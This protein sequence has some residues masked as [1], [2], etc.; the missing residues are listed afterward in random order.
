MG[1]RGKRTDLRVRNM[2]KNYDNLDGNTRRELY[3]YVTNHDTYSFTNIVYW[4]NNISDHVMD[5]INFAFTR[6][7]NNAIH[8]RYFLL[9]QC[10]EQYSITIK[11]HI[12][13]EFAGRG[14]I[15]KDVVDLCKKISGSIRGGLTQYT[16]SQKFVH[17]YTSY[18]DQSQLQRELDF[19][20]KYAS[21]YTVDDFYDGLPL[22]YQ[23]GVIL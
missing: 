21:G 8:N 1:A 16:N 6:D 17:A 5:V 12:Y 23:L 10:D 11:R 4:I 9:I 7:S 2:L 18:Y 14:N 22:E 15:N 13:Q 20:H 3:E 19:I